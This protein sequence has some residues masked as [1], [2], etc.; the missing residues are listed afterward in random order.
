MAAVWVLSKARVVRARWRELTESEDGSA[1]AASADSTSGKKSPYTASARCRLPHQAGTSWQI[2]FPIG[3]REN[4][5][6][7]A[8]LHPLL[9]FNNI[10]LRRWHINPATRRLHLLDNLVSFLIFP[11]DANE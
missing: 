5:G 9:L 3:K 4:P 11:V 6:F 7:K 2:R 8:V 10:L 1:A